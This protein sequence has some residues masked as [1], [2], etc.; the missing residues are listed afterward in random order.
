MHDLYSP[1]SHTFLSLTMFLWGLCSS[2]DK[3][4]AASLTADYSAFSRC[5]SKSYWMRDKTKISSGNLWKVV[6][7]QSQIQML[8]TP[9]D[10]CAVVPL[11]YLQWIC[12]STPSGSLKPGN[13]AEPY[14]HSLP[15]TYMHTSSLKGH[16]WHIFFGRSKVP[17][18]LLVLREP[19]LSKIR[20]PGT[21]TKWYLNNQSDNLDGW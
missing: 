9:N 14:R 2:L 21:Q 20:I 6:V 11:T 16:T 12:L 1:L 17:A 13:N 4:R 19:L 10:V 8:Y 18:L 15:S 7:H 3:A 5:S